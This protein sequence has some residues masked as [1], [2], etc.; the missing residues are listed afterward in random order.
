MLGMIKLPIQA[1]GAHWMTIL[2]AIVFLPF[3]LVYMLFHLIV[4]YKRKEKTD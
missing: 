2:F 4:S 3:L 1:K